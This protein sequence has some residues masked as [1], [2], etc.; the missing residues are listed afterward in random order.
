GGGVGLARLRGGR[1]APADGAPDRHRRPAPAR[2]DAD[3]PRDGALP[4]RNLARLAARVPLG[5]RRRARARRRRPARPRRER[6]RGRVRATSPSASTP[7][8]EI[9]EMLTEARDIGAEIGDVE[10]EAEAIEWRIAALMHLGEM[11]AARREL[12]IGLEMAERMRQ[13]FVIHV[14]EQYSS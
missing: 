12:A 6:V 8:S 1:G 11:D 9:V 13:P 5:G 10:I 14:A 4:R 7:V 3:R 2:G